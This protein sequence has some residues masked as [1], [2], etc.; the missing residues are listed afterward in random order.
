MNHMFASYLASHLSLSPHRTYHA[1]DCASVSTQGTTGSRGSKG[2]T[3]GFKAKAQDYQVLV[4]ELQKHQAQFQHARSQ[5]ASSLLRMG[6]YH[7]RNGEYDEATAALRESLNENRSVVCS[8]LS[9]MPS[10]DST[11]N[12][13]ES[14]V[15]GLSASQSSAPYTPRGGISVTSSSSSPYLSTVVAKDKSFT[16]SDQDMVAT[17]RKSLG[18]M[19]TTLS[20]LGKVHS[21]RGEDAAAM[22][23][24]DEKTK[25]QSF[26]MNIEEQLSTG[27]ATC[28]GSSAGVFFAE[29]HK[30]I[31]TEINEDV[32]ALDELFRGISFRGSKPALEEFK[33]QD[34]ETRNDNDAREFTVC[35]G[36]ERSA[37]CTS[38]DDNTSGSTY[39]HDTH[40]RRRMRVSTKNDTQVS[41]S[42]LPPLRQTRF[43]TTFEGSTIPKED[44]EFADAVDTYRTVIDSYGGC[45]TDKHEKK[46]AEVLRKYEL[47]QSTRTSTDCD[48]KHSPASQ[49]LL[50]WREEWQLALDIYELALC[51]QRE[52]TSR[53]TFFP[54]TPRKRTASDFG[55]DAHLSDASILIAMGGLY[56]KL[57]NVQLELEKYNEA[58]TVYQ[59]ALGQDHPHVAGTM[60][61]IGMVLA[62]QGQLDEA[63][64]KFQEARKIYKTI[65]ERKGD[66]PCCDVASAL[67]CMGNVHYRQGE[68]EDALR[69][70][71]EALSIYKS[72]S[73]RAQEMGGHSRLALQDVASTLKIMGMV[74]TKRGELD[75]AMNCFQDAIDIMRQNFNE[76][77]SG[78]LV[79]SILSRIGGIFSK[80][81]KLEEAMSH[82]HEAYD[83]ATR[84]YGTTDHPDVA[85]VLHYIGGI[86][87]RSGKLDEAMRC[88]KNSAKIYQITLGR[89]DPI[90]ATTLVCI[91]SV[92][93]IEKNLDGAMNYYK[94]ALR[95]NKS[96]YGTKHPDVIPTMKSIALIH[97]KKG[98]FDHAIETF[99]EVL[100]IKCSEVGHFHP[101]VAGAH[102]RIGNVHYQR[103]D[104]SSAEGEYR[105]A[106]SIYQQNFGDEHQA[107]K[108]ALHIVEKVA[109]EIADAHLSDK[110]TED[111]QTPLTPPTCCAIDDA[112]ETQQSSLSSTSFFK[113]VPKGYESL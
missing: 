66:G 68:L 6:E 93:Y 34:E 59:E 103:G 22:K 14:L 21:L 71:G 109:K 28:L 36:D 87:Q 26:R 3:G 30:N 38:L 39:S 94:E 102:K 113:R 16:T 12:G 101:E 91:G 73:K 15:S 56:Y 27:M 78:P 57:N 81:G 55:Q 35:T 25:M 24:Y 29:G 83:L 99:T 51:A 23:Y 105:K 53:T 10:L 5:L 45:N 50:A 37:N 84:T 92:H 75:L 20:N 47:I 49:K 46:Y 2:S 70:Y 82:Y 76:K 69:F 72:A 1:S 32:K 44:N 86:H 104:L 74:H 33:D 111:T 100:K 13:D 85:Q 11:D 79:T 43:P 97:A 40:R 65:N 63:M 58:L 88:Y 60:K 54:G 41:V 42:A 112:Y 4:T 89:N 107:T 62:E 9:S 96:A 80:M 108:S 95:I 52:A 17:Q 77:T 19:I 48:T 64:S 7:I 110:D 61:N 98:N 106:L 90:V 31:M 18:D 67:S 8:S